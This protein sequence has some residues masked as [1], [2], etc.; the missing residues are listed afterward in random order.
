MKIRH[1]EAI[2]AVMLTGTVSGASRLLNLT[3]PAV[4]RTLQHAELQLGFPLFL[5]SKNRLIPT[6]EAVLLN[7]EIGKLFGQLEAVHR[8]AASLRAGSVDQ[9]RIMMVPAL[10]QSVLP[11][12][13]AMFRERHPEAPVA[14]R[15][16]NSREI[17]AALPL[18]EADIG[19][20]FGPAQHPAISDDVLSEHNVVCVAPKG[21]FGQCKEVTLPDL[22]DKPVVM[23]DQGDYLSALLSE[24]RREEGGSQS[25]G[26]TVQ[27]YH[28]A[29]A[30][31]HNGIGAA[32]IDSFTAASA[33][34]EKVDVL[35]LAPALPMSTRVLHMNNVEM[36]V[37]LR[38]F[39]QCFKL[40]A[41]EV[42]CST[43][44]LI[45]AST[46]ESPVKKIA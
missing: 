24:A 22:I 11:R 5:R 34:I 15:M 27:T 2:H 16:L 19:F 4:T 36:S 6:Q 13:L 12:A 31:A 3:Q 30:L 39:I 33:D 44:A 14:V 10:G 29:L 41:E 35:R 40:A 23:H 20:T 8:L 25:A 7:G 42:V 46:A 9:I 45:S 43:E 38:Y 32:L 1:V 21:M 37:Q 26:I 28:A 18:R 17:V